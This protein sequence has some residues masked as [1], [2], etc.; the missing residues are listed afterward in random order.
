MKDEERAAAG[1]RVMSQLNVMRMGRGPDAPPLPPR[2]GSPLQVPPATRLPVEDEATAA[3]AYAYGEVWGRPGL[4]MKTREHCVLAAVQALCH[5]DQ[6]HIHTNNA[7]N[8]GLTP[9]EIHET[10]LHAGVYAGITT[11]HNATN[12]ARWVFLQRGIV[13]PAAALAPP[14]ARTMTQAERRAAYERVAAALGLGRLGPAADAPPLRPLPGGPQAVTARTR[15]PIEEEISQLQAEYGYGEVWGRPG[16]SLR[17]RSFITM[18]VLQV[19]HE[20]DQLHTHV[21]NAL[22]LGITPEEVH[23][24]FMQVGVYGGLSGWHNAVNVARDV[25]I[26]RGVL[27]A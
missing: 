26:Q 5:D 20:N 3:Q 14:G 10:F 1:A 22:N 13:Q 18:A 9:E 19:E 6:I 27:E 4:D 25:F 23:E 24:C 15:L 17:T 12:H 21:N 16:L 2:P 11:W 7:L 8:V